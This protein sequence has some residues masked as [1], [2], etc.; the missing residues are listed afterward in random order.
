MSTAPLPVAF[1]PPAP[2]VRTGARPALLVAEF[3]GTGDLAI[4][5]PFL[6]AALTRYDVTLLAVPNAAGLL[7]RFAPEVELIPCVAPWAL[8][9]G[10]RNLPRWPWRALGRVLRELRARRFAAAVSIWPLASDHLFLRLARPGRLL[11]YGRR[12]AGWLLDDNLADREHVHR[13]EAWRQLAARLDLPLV[14]AATPRLLSGPA[15]RVVLHSGASQPLRVWPLARYA[16]LLRRLRAQG[17][18]PVVL[19]DPDQVP[20][21]RALGEPL[22]RAA[23]GMDDLIDTIAGA[24]AFLGNDSGPGHI[25]ALCGV[26]TFTIFGPQVPDLFAPGHP[27]AEWIEGRPCPYKPCYDRC[28]YAEPFCLTGIDVETV[29]P[30][31][32]P[33]LENVNR[34]VLTGG[35]EGNQ[36]R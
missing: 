23:A 35:N 33:W 31:L 2:R 3:R 32:N 11:G 5:V 14:P 15:R 28:R 7:R 8:F 6:R 21:W 36:G 26:A 16:E 1:S 20:A 17:W 25:A 27:Q 18:D 4:L 12:G 9:S 24:A 30:K 29:W 34:S 19:C 22:A 13:P 10:G